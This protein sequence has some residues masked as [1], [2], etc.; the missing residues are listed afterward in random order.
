MQSHLKHILSS[1][2]KWAWF[3]IIS[4]ISLILMQ[5]VHLPWEKE[6]QYKAFLK[7]MMGLC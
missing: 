1:L 5:T 6:I 4:E 2:Y 7:H 3:T